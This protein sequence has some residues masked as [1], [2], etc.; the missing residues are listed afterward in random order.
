MSDRVFFTNLGPHKLFHIAKKINLIENE[1]QISISKFNNEKDTIIK[2]INN[3]KIPQE[4]RY[5]NMRGPLNPDRKL[6]PSGNTF[7][8]L[9]PKYRY[10][11]QKF[12]MLFILATIVEFLKSGNELSE[13]TNIQS[14]RRNLFYRNNNYQGT[15]E[16]L[17][18]DQ[19]GAPLGGGGVADTP[20]SNDNLNQNFPLVSKYKEIIG[21]YI[22]NNN[23]SNYD[24]ITKN[25]INYVREISN[26]INDYP[27]QTQ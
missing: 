14:F 24:N 10:I 18:R 26:Q 9:Q 22:N 13:N 17:L 20:I 19:A 6:E 12:R 25:I 16:G 3:K 23:L 5:K 11:P 2:D 1:K 21:N 8:Y 27:M 4:P 7:L 15:N